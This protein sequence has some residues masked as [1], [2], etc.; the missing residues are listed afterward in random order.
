MKRIYF[1]SDV[2]NKIRDG[3]FPE[4]AKVLTKHKDRLLI[5][6]SPAHVFDKLSTVSV[7]PELFWPEM[8]YITEFTQSKLLR[9]DRKT[10]S[11]YAEIATGREVAEAIIDADN[12]KRKYENFGNIVQE[13]HAFDDEYPIEGHKEQLEK[14]RSML[15]QKFPISGQE[16]IP[17]KDHIQTKMDSHYE[18]QH[19]PIRYRELRHQM[20]KELRLENA[21]NWK[22]DIMSQVDAQIQTKTEHSDFVSY[23]RGMIDEKE[24][25]DRC[26]IYTQCYIQLGNLGYYPDKITERKGIKNHMYDALHSYYAGHCDYFVLMDERLEKKS[27][28]L[29]QA[30]KIDT[31]IIRYDQLLEELELTLSAP[32]KLANL[33]LL[34][35]RDGVQA[36]KE[37]GD[38]LTATFKLDANFLDYFTH[39]TVEYGHPRG[40]MAMVYTKEYYNYSTFLFFHEFDTIITRVA[41]FLAVHDTLTLLQK[42]KKGVRESGI[43]TEDIAFAGTAFVRLWAN[44]ERIDMCIM[45]FSKEMRVEI[46]KV[47]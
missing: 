41:E 35:E 2:I 34:Y 16:D 20:Y 36:F 29:Y 33:E 3:Q 40:M 26:L 12:L 6:F 30:L 31:K 27:R 46:I 19:N 28:A 10:K 23:V 37:S 47:V 11:M 7:R 22:G 44:R 1:D 17:L 15:D 32:D 9:F 42:F 45:I 24:Q 8:D 21:S 13:L 18:I 43:Y 4:L 25:D 5:P 14:L 38:L 39:V